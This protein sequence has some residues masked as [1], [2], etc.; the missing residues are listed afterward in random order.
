MYHHHHLPARFH[1]I[2]IN[3]CILYDFIKSNAHSQRQRRRLNLFRRLISFIYF[4]IIVATWHDDRNI[5]RIETIYVL[6]THS[7]QF[8]TTLFWLKCF[9]LYEIVLLLFCE[10]QRKKLYYYDD[11]LYTYMKNMLLNF[12]LLWK[13]WKENYNFIWWCFGLCLHFCRVFTYTKTRIV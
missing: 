11:Y 3:Y 7:K 8:K 10:Q 13:S 1:F 9:L 12:V 2:T 5:C 6:Y 4:S